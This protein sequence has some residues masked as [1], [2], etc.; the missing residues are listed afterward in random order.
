MLPWT[1]DFISF[2]W[3]AI[4]GNVLFQMF[5]AEW[6][7]TQERC[8]ISVGSWIWEREMPLPNQCTQFIQMTPASEHMTDTCIRRRSSTTTTIEESCSCSARWRVADGCLCSVNEPS[9]GAERDHSSQR[10]V[11]LRSV[12]CK[13]Y[14]PYVLFVRQCKNIHEH[15]MSSSDSRLNV[16]VMALISVIGQ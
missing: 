11:V 2:Q 16:G 7:C 6:P 9:V 8:L 15:R 3:S 13:R 14:F 4:L 10:K 1:L 12:R 5:T